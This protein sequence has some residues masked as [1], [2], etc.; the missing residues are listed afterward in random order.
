MT[1][2]LLAV[3]LLVG[4]AF[5]AL[6]L[7]FLESEFGAVVGGAVC[8]AVA[9]GYGTTFVVHVV[10]GKTYGVADLIFGSAQASIVLLVV[11]AG[12]LIAWRVRRYRGPTPD[13]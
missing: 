11:I 1:L 2:G 8:V 6:A 7:L 3:A 9:I 5:L 12:L 10:G 4:A 13:K